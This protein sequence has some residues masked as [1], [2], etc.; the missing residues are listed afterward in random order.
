MNIISDILYWIS[1]GLLVP[2]IVLLI[3]LFGRALLLVGSFYGQYL[4]IRKTEALLRNELNALT[5]A[6]VMELADKLPEKSSSLVIS[7]IRQVLQAHESP[8]QIQRLLANFEIAADKDLAIS[9]TLT[10]LGPILGLMGTLIPMGPALAGLASGDIASMAY[11][12]QIAFA[13]T[14]VGLVAGAVGFLTQQVKQRWYL[15]DMTNLKFLSELLNEK[16][17]AR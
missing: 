12:M 16:R 4:S 1:T 10:K 3:V 17:A 2:D 14:V 5:P 15:Q 11:N 7:Y 8:A 13:T 9:K 6:T